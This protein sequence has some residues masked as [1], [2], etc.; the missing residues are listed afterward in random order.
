MQDYQAQR[1]LNYGLDW[2]A[3]FAWTLTIAAFTLLSLAS[4]ALF[5]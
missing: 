3:L 2:R 1:L 4:V 5:R